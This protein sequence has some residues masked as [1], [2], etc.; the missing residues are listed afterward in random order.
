MERILLPL[1]IDVLKISSE[2]V[3]KNGEGVNCSLGIV[4]DFHH[5]N[6]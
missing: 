5:D 2:T 6:D 4:D 3:A 1:G